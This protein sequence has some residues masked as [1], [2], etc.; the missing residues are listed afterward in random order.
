MQKRPGTSHQNKSVCLVA[1]QVHPKIAPLVVFTPPPLPLP[2]H[3]QHQQVSDQTCPNVARFVWALTCAM[4]FY[5]FMDWLSVV[6]TDPNPTPET[7]L[8]GNHHEPTRHP[9][10]C[11]HANTLW[12][13]FTGTPTGCKLQRKYFWLNSGPNDS[14]RWLGSSMFLFIH[15]SS[16]TSC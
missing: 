12:S 16:F 4:S 6:R 7:L 3:Q 9:Q 11:S 5:I 1:V 14:C 2:L 15:A 8:P 13:H 10:P